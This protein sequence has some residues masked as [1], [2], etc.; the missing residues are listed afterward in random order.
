MSEERLAAIE[1]KIDHLDAK[2]DELDTRLTGKIDLVDAKID[3]LDTR[4]TGKIHELRRHM[5]V[6][7]EETLERIAALAPDYSTIRRE[8]TAA[9]D[10][11][12]DDISR[13]L[14]PLE[15]AVRGRKSGRP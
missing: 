12:R 7:H 2:V 10:R 11:V 5:G 4:L 13:R 3:E 6:L 14:D 9:D 15:A 1:G 8:F